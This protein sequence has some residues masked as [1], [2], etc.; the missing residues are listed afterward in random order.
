MPAQSATATLLSIILAIP[1]LTIYGLF[2]SAILAGRQG[3][4]FLIVLMTT[5]LLIPVLI[6]GVEATQSYT[7]SGL[8]ALEFRV[9]I[10]LSLISIA[11]GLPAAAAA[12]KANLE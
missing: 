1:A 8:H 11:V 4:G 10:G 3:G 2:A 12:L 6:F 9:L 7:Q 5:P